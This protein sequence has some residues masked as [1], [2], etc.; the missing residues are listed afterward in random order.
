MHLILDKV[1]K[2]S[3]IMKYVSPVA[4]LV[5][6]EAIDVLLTSDVVEGGDAPVCPNDVEGDCGED[7]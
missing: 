1:K 6:L 4:E 2:E 7:W 5:A 3:M